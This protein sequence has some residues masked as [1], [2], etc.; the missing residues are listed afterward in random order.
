MPNPES[1]T[2][3][4]RDDGTFGGLADCN[5]FAG[6]YSTE[7]GFSLTLGPTT[8][9][10]CGEESLDQQYL[11]LLDMVAAGGPTGEGTL[12]LESA[13]GADRMIFINGGPAPAE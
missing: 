9:A 7:S 10:F 8:A 3:T 12:A 13:G 6:D 4:F 2:I 1:Y 11:G 5:N